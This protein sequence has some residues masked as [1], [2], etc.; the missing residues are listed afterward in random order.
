MPLNEPL[1]LSKTFS[2]ELA[3]ITISSVLEFCGVV[4]KA[5]AYSDQKPAISSLRRNLQ[6]EAL[7]ELA[8]LSLGGGRRTGLLVTRF[9]AGQGI[10]P[11]A[12]SLANFHL[13]RLLQ[14]VIEV[15]SE[16]GEQAQEL[17]LDDATRAHLEDIQRRVEAVLEA[18]IVVSS[19]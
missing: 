19:P 15:L 7:G 3:L 9:G 1:K 14:R 6:R 17:V 8:R 11:D 16:G 10:P 18:E 2:F 13:K 12:R 4:L 5:A